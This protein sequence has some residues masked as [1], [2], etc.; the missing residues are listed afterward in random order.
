MTT[1]ST[2]E[3]LVPI[4]K[5]VLRRSSIQAN[6]DFFDLGGD[7]ALAAQLF[8]EIAKVFGRHLSPVLICSGR[9]IESLAAIL[10]RPE[11][12]RI[13]PLLLLKRGSALPAIFIAHGLGDTVLNL[14]PLT[15]KI[16]SS[17]PIY[18]LQARG[19]DGIDKP[20]TTIEEMAQFHLDAIKQI[21]PHGPHFLMG[22]S[23][24]GLVAL[25]IAQRLA[26]AGERV[27]LLA[28]I[29]SYPDRRQLGVGQRALLSFRLAKRRLWSRR[30]SGSRE[31]RSQISL[32]SGNSAQT[33]QSSPARSV[34]EQMRESAYLALRRYRPRF[35]PGK[36]RF[37]KAEISTDFPSDP[38]AVWSHLAQQFEVDTIPGDH[39]SMLTTQFDKLAS[40]LT[41]YID[42]SHT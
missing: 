23:L 9:T 10:Q 32:I 39:I 21:Q 36:I 31:T 12:L 6:D 13:P 42:E 17:N 18:G 29:D 3:L 27:A 16:Q 7:P 30:E 11:P 28:L 5:R 8:S 24:G 34:A 33:N 20:L 15:A 40:I 26:A 37:V 38:V 19:I 1:T 35:Y 25:E 22:Y 14:F 2:V 4:W 41:D